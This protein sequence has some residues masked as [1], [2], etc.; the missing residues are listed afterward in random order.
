MH[1][2]RPY[3]A[4]DLQD[5]ERN[6]GNR[7]PLRGPAVPRRPRKASWPPWLFRHHA[8]RLHSPSA[9]SRWPIFTSCHAKLRCCTT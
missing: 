1:F 4:N 7:V 9:R 2:M 6:S 8:Q 5:R 3:P